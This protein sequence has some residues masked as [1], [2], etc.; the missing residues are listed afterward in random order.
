MTIDWVTSDCYGTLIDWEGG[1]TAALSP[2][3]PGVSRERIVARYMEIEANV[4]RGDYLPYRE[5]LDITSRWLLRDL[6]HPL[7]DEEQSPLGASLP[8]WQ[9]FP[10]VP[11]ALRALR[12]RGYRFAILSNVDRNLLADSVR[13]LGIQPDLVVTA[14]DCASYKP[15]AGHWLYFRH[16]T[17]AHPARTVH[18]GASIYHDMRPAGAMGYRTVFVDRHGEAVSPDVR[19]LR[20]L[21]DLSGLPDVIDEFAGRFARTM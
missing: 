17:G 12:A 14:E 18:V 20:T 7:P 9:P 15:S 8:E 21:P 11:A 4:E 13:R 10:E 16:Q 5:V 1:I 6:G 2:L 3:L 19:P